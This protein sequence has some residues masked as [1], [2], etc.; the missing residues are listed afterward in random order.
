M[1]MIGTSYLLSAVRQLRTD[2]GLAEVDSSTAV[3]KT[4]AAATNTVELSASNTLLVRQ[5]LNAAADVFT[6]IEMTSVALDRVA[7]F[8]ADMEANEIGKNSFTTG[9]AEYV[10]LETAGTQLQRDLTDYVSNNIVK[11]TGFSVAGRSDAD[12]AGGAVSDQSYF[13]L[14]TWGKGGVAGALEAKV[15]TLGLMAQDL[16]TKLHDPSSCP[17]CNSGEPMNAAPTTNSTTNVGSTSDASTTVTNWD[18]LRSGSLWNVAIGGT[19]AGG[20]LSYSYYNGTTSYSDPYNGNQAGGP[21]SGIITALNSTQQ[22]D[23]DAVMAAWDAVIDPDFDKVTEANTS[24]VG[25]IRIA[26]TSAGPSGSAAYAYYPSNSNVG[27]DTWYMSTVSSNDSFAAGTYGMLTALHEIGH[28]LGLKHPFQSS[29]S[30]G[31]L[32][33]GDDNARNSVMTYTQDDRNYIWNVTRNGSSISAGVVKAN[34]ITPMLYDVAFAQENYGTEASVRPTDTLYSFAVAPEVLQTIVDGDGTDTIDASALSRTSIINLTPGAFSSIGYISSADQATAQKAA[35]PGFNNWIDTLYGSSYSGKI[36][37]WDDNVA[38]AYSAT[39][40]N[41]IGGSGA[42]TITGNT[43][44]NELWGKGG[45]DTINGGA[46]VDTAGFTGNYAQYTIAAGAATVTD[47]V[48]GR[49]G[50][51]TISNV[52]FLKFAD[53]TYNVATGA[54]SPTGSASAPSGASQ[55]AGGP[56]A[57]AAAAAAAAVTAGNASAA[58]AAATPA[59]NTVVSRSSAQ[60]KSVRGG[61]IAALRAVARSISGMRSSLK[62]SSV[63]SFH[64]MASASGGV[65]KASSPH[66]AKT[67]MVSSPSRAAASAAMRS[68]SAASSAQ[69]ARPPMINLANRAEFSQAFSVNRAQ[70]MAIVAR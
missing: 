32:A 33:S 61:R 31:T 21:Q 13:D 69:A 2:R 36:Y 68:M 57:A 47:S 52:E 49:D 45:N 27:G 12:L 66:M 51:D 37:Q 14:D 55:S 1:T 29:G 39:I 20:G 42:D 6:E 9:T 3:A 25:E 22:T 63:K 41:A 43:V 28:A 48:S 59:G 35:N 58:A 60:A 70:V 15:A 50:T 40:E 64:G 34:P 30:A 62:T 38:I 4:L 23:H 10:A 18:A 54:T 19:Q 16:T 5:Q 24:T 67:A 17:I 26:Y 65:Q 8:I 56:S 46:G 7:G 53:L 11:L 44:A